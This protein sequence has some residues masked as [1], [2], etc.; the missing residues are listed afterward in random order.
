[1]KRLTKV[2]SVVLA[3]VMLMSMG[4]YSSAKEQYYRLGDFDLDGEITAADARMVLRASV[5]LETLTDFQKLISDYDD[6]GDISAADA[7][8][9]LRTCVGLETVIYVDDQG[10][11]YGYLKETNTYYL[12]KNEGY[13][14]YTGQKYAD[15]D[16][17]PEDSWYI[18]VQKG[19]V[20]YEYKP[21]SSA[22]I[23]PPGP[24][25]S[26]YTEET[27]PYY[28]LPEVDADGSTVYPKYAGLY[29][30]NN[31]VH[32][33][34]EDIGEGELY[35]HFDSKGVPSL[36][37]KPSSEPEPDPNICRVCGK[38]NFF[39][40]KTGNA[41]QF[42][43]CTRWLSDVTCSNCGQ[44]VP[45]YTCHTCPKEYQKPVPTVTTPTGPR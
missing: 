32:C 42:G 14:S 37:R 6:D 5:G 4:I 21:I 44:K 10:E 20:Y 35:W 7:R 43:G 9:V 11:R 12:L 1:M 41:C 33:D 26:K 27:D 40:N 8:M 39:G 2:M 15:Y 16:A 3:F 25:M 17:I 38:I 22:P 30:K 24:P 28:W 13:F 18:L 31:G 19:S 29:Y 45:A 34:Y 36:K 23:D